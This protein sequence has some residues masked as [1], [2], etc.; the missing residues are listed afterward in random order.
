MICSGQ[1]AD[2]RKKRWC[3]TPWPA[4][5]IPRRPE[6]YPLGARQ[7]IPGS[8]AVPLEIPTKP[9]AF[10]PHAE[11][12]ALGLDTPHSRGQSLWRYVTALSRPKRVFESR[13]SHH[14]GPAHVRLPPCGPTRG[15]AGDAGDD[16]RLHA[17]APRLL[18]SES[19][20]RRP[21]ADAARGVFPHGLGPP[22]RPGARRGRG[23]PRPGSFARRNP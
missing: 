16:H 14:R 21:A 5:G 1:S 15:L 8:P 23:C 10:C 17:Q 20:A 18:R 7:P 6:Q 9:S 3:G 2:G 12:R 13:W 22:P 19:R 4:S 11:S